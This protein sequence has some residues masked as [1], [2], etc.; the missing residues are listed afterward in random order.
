[1]KKITF[2]VFAIAF[3]T[4]LSFADRHTAHY[5][6]IET[7]NQLE[8]KGFSIHSIP[9]RH[10]RYNHYR[11]YNRFLYRG[12]CYGIIG[13]GDQYVRDLDVIIYDKYWRYVTADTGSSHVSAVDFCPR[14]TGM[15][16]IRTRMRGGS[17]YFYQVIG[18]RGYTP[19]YSRY[20]Y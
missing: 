3:F 18:H 6:A 20:Y 7:A 8:A 14:H 5:R 4:Q 17:G 9:G 19:A 13:V 1:M 16:H 11:T 15:Y 12:T 10:L 2:I